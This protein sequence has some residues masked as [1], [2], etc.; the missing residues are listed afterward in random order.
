MRSMS[1]SASQV[2]SIRMPGSCS[3][4]IVMPCRVFASSLRSNLPS[5][6]VAYF[7]A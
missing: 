4:V 2:V 6:S 7:I 1:P 5:F 3:G